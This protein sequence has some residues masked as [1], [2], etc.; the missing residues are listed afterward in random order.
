VAVKAK[1]IPPMLLLKTEKL[2]DD[3][4]WL[5]QLKLDGYRAIAFRTGGKLQLRSRNDTGISRN[6][7]RVS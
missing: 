3:P 7:I 6:G 5:Y 2:P 4:R 1:F